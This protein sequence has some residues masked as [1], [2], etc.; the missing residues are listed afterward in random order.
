MSRPWPIRIN[1]PEQLLTA[2]LRAFRTLTYPAKCGP[3]VLAFC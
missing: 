2:L 1:R 3:V